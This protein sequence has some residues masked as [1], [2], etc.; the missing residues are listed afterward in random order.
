MQ[1]VA[2]AAV[3]G[4]TITG[5]LRAGVPA[6]RRGRR[7]T[8]SWRSR[9]PARSRRRSRAPSWRPSRSPP[10]ASASPS[11]T[12]GPCR[13]GLGTIVIA[14]AERRPPPA[15]TLHSTR[16]WPLATD[17][18]GRT[19]VFGALDTLENLKKGGRIGN[20]KALLG[21][22]ALDQA[23]HRGRRTASSSRTAS[24]APDA[25]RSGSSSTR[26]PRRGPRSS[27]S[28]CS[29]PTAATS[30]SSS[31]SCGRYYPGE[32]VVGQIG[33]VVGAHAGRGTIGVAFQERP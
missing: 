22:G 31:P 29:T 21:D 30:T 24:S 16:S 12:A 26:S 17:L 2:D 8:T 7:P 5:P 18:V 10:T 15:T 27:T 6:T 20:A 9:S 3:D 32:I 14:C 23:D 1:G 19:R 11:S 25:R 33:P 28:P 4:R 13:S